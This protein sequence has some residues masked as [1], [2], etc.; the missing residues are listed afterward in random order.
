MNNKYPCLECSNNVKNN[1]K[2]FFCNNC[3]QWVHLKCT[4]LTSNDYNQLA[5]DN[6]TWFCEICLSMMFPYNNIVDEFDYLCSIN[7]YVS[8]NEIN[9]DILLNMLNSLN[10]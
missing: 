9:M 8:S 4:R 10:L 7:N 6:S 1:Q 2:A 5:D 3:L